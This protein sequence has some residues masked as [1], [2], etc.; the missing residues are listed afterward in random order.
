MAIVSL[1]AFAVRSVGLTRGFELWVDEMLYADL[2]ASVSRGE[3]PNLP[4]GPFFLHP[5]GF[6]IIEGLVIKVFGLDTSDSMSL[7]YELR[8]LSATLGAVSVGLAFL[9]VRQVVGTRLAWLSAAILVFDP[10]VLRTNSRV[11]LE[12]A[13][14]QF[15]LVGFLLL[16]TYLN[17]KSIKGQTRTLAMAGLCLGGAVFTKDAFLVFGVLP[18]VLAALWRTTLQRREALVV[19]VSALVPYVT[20]LLLLLAVGRIH[21][22]AVAKENGLLRLFGVVQSTGFNAPDA[23]SL[24]NRLVVQAEQYGTS[25]LLLLA[26]GVAGVFASLSDRPARRLVGLSAV[27]MGMLGCFISLFGT[28]EEQ[29]GYG[30][31]L[32]AV[33]AL[34]VCAA[35]VRERRPTLRR[36]VAVIAALFLAATTVL[37]VRLGL[38]DDAGYLQFRSWEATHLGAD[39]RVGVTNSTADWALQDDPRFGPWSSPSLLKEHRAQ[40]LLTQSLPASQG[41]DRIRPDMLTWLS[42]N[43]KPVFIHSGPTN[44]ETVLWFI[45]EATLERAAAGHVGESSQEPGSRTPPETGRN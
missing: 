33:P 15:V 23:P 27:S 14:G 16:V 43:A 6:F 9:I 45:D 18:V 5:P 42:V 20:Y 44:G 28:F 17:R 8:W 41:Y 21:D 22:W 29:Y 32:A 36:T 37:G 40:Y 13:A 11:F 25:Y 39:A 31:A 19:L 30:I 3:L 34:A 10:F 1:A 24:T 35:E 12:T 2:G 38:T 26:C 7:V 4:D